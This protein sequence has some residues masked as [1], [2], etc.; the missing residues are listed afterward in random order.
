MA[1]LEDIRTRLA[2]LEQA[3][4]GGAG[5]EED[6]AALAPRRDEQRATP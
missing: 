4:A 1:V 3:S 6:L 5:V 2:R